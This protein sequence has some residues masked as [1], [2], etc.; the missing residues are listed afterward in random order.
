MEKFISVPWNDN[1]LYGILHEPDS[2]SDKMLVFIHGIPGDRVDARRL[3][4]RIARALLKNRISSLRIDLFASGVS[5]GDFVNVTL[6]SQKEQIGCV[7]KYIR[8]ELHY[9]GKIIL[10]AFSEAAKIANIIARE[11]RDID[12]ICYCNG[13]LVREE[14]ADSLRVKRL[15]MRKGSFVANIG[16]GVWL[17]SNIISEIEQWSLCDV[18]DLADVKTLFIYGD[19]DDLTFR[20]KQFVNQIDSDYY[21][22]EIIKGADHLFTNSAFDEGI[23]SRINKWVIETAF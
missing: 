9:V 5:E 22:V 1:F 10:V 6:S 13:I 15:Y 21:Q 2:L 16:F 18:N 3:P 12:G 4:V 23:I 8:C 19:E 17:N 20:S 14:I 11:Y 7:I